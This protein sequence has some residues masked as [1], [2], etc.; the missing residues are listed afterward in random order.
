MPI[1]PE[2]ELETADGERALAAAKDGGARIT[3]DVGSDPA[4]EPDEDEGLKPL[5][6]RL[7]SELTAYR[8]VALRRR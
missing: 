5:S 3:A 6:D 8:T 7:V 1:E 4:P 2:P